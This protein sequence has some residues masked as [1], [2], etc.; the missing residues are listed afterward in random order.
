V[1]PATA[2]PWCTFTDPEL[3]RI[4]PSESEALRQGIAHRVHRF[5]F[6]DN[7]RAR[8]DGDTDGF[9]KLVTE[10]GGRILGAAIVG[11]HAGELI[12]EYALAIARGLKAADVS[13]AIHVYPTLSQAS[14][15]VA[16]ARMK[17]ALT[18]AAKR[19]LRFLFGLRGP[20]S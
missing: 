18:P 13:A 1:K 19:W 7:D 12:A 16:D 5:A 15:R 14:R 4:G 11:A 3:A 20:V 9:A 8:A 17:D 2:I 10:P 6:A